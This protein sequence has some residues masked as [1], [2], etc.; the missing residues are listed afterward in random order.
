MRFFQLVHIPFDAPRPT[1][2][3][4]LTGSFVATDRSQFTRRF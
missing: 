1:V 3:A 4:D 2:P